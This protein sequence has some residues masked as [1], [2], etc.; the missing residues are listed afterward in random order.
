MAKAREKKLRLDQ[1][2]GLDNQSPP[3]EVGHGGLVR[4]CNV[5]AT[6]GLHYERRPGYT[7]VW[8]GA[9]QAAWSEGGV[10]LV[11]TT[12]G[13][14]LRV[15][16]QPT[17]AG[18]GRGALPSL[19]V[20]VLANGIAGE[21]LT[22]CAVEGR[23]YLSTGR[24]GLVLDGQTARPLGLAPPSA[25]TLTQI[26]G[27]L[28]AGRYLVDATAV[29]PDGRESGS[30]GARYIDLPEPG[31]APGCGFRVEVRL[32]DDAALDLIPR[33][34]LGLPNA[35]SLHHLG[36]G[37]SLSVTAIAD[38]LRGGPPLQRAQL[39]PLPPGRILAEYG[40]RLLVAAGTE[41]CFSEPF[42]PES[43]SPVAGRIPFGSEVTLLRSLGECLYIS[44]SERIYCLTGALD[45][46]HRLRD[47]YPYPALPGT[48]V[49]VSL[50]RIGNGSA[51]G[52][53]CVFATPAGICCAYP[54]GR[55]VNLTERR[56][57]MPGARAGTARI[58][59]HTYVCALRR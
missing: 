45:G 18:L 10:C 11:L 58:E 46:E 8:A 48:D 29:A 23:V 25:L 59:D 15:E 56:I 12:T 53:G 26:K 2:T 6:R 30:I 36:E 44:T 3:L 49:R 35:M 41:V 16:P 52:F 50:S 19:D 7:Q 24:Q 31:G 40:G 27:G 13:T 20:T 39:R 22:G 54:D 1:W 21:T 4:A 17:I 9:I 57:A 28:P 55:V 37:Q 32:S 33:V 47:A 42:D 51:H 38:T 34:Y 5:R 14:L 43:H